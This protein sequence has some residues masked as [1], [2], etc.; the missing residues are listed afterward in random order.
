M[1]MLGCLRSQFI[2]QSLALFVISYISSKLI[3][4]QCALR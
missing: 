4:T 2:Y 3:D 1:D